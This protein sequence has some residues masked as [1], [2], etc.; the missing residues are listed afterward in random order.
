MHIAISQKFNPKRWHVMKPNMITPI[1]PPIKPS[2]VL[3][4]LIFGAIEFFPILE[5]TRNAKLSK[6]AVLRIKIKNK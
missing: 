1:K 3:L 6:I 4:G 2:I 5:P